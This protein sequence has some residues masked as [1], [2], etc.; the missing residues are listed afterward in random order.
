M[1]GHNRALAFACSVL[2]HI[3][4]TSGFSIVQTTSQGR[5]TTKNAHS[6]CLF[7]DLSSSTIAPVH[8]GFAPVER[9]MSCLR[10]TREENEGEVEEETSSTSS[11]DANA[12]TTIDKKLAGRKKRLRL[13][14]QAAS[15]GYVLT[16]LFGL[17]SWGSLSASAFYYAVGGGPLN[18]A[19]ILYILKGAAIH[20]RL[21]SDT[22]KR[23]NIAVIF[24]ALTQLCIP[25]GAL[26]WSGSTALKI[27][28]FLAFVNGIKGYG[29]GVLGWDKSKDASTMLTDIKEGIQ[30]TVKGL[31]TVKAKSAGYILGTLLLGSMFCLKLKELCTMASSFSSAET[32]TRLS[33]LARFGLMT[34]I[35]YTLKDA[36]DRDRLSGTTFV[37]LNYVAATAFLSIS[38]YLL[39]TYG[40]FLANTQILTAS[41]LFAVT[42]FKALTSSKKAKS[43]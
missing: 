32:V 11:I 40:K 41:G 28:G 22:Y 27:P 23:L 43:A 36:S 37:Q 17:V 19:V 25:T 24:Y 8:C 2:F 34:T 29:Y 13:G 39:P 12:E 14:Y 21:G 4:S 16:S 38:L 7:R 15:I 9:H 33:K 3:Q 31:T 42:L 5:S 20:D 35:M 1:I 26:G 10:A 18:M 30:S 6:S